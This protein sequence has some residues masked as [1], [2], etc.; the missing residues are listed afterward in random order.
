MLRNKIRRSCLLALLVAIT[1]VRSSSGQASPTLTSNAATL[2][3]ADDRAA[4][5]VLNRRI[6]IDL[7]DVTLLE[8]LF[9][10]RDLTGIN[11]VVGNEITG[12]V[13]AAFAD[14]QVHQVLDSLLIPRGYS[15]R[16]V[17][18]SLAILSL[19]SIG[20]MLP[21]FESRVIRL[22]SNS[23]ESLLSIVE[24][25][26]S[27]E[28]RVHAVSASNT[29]MIMDYADRIQLTIDQIQALE[30]AAADHEAAQ[31]ATN[32]VTSSP[33]AGQAGTY[34]RI[35]RPQFVPASTLLESLRPLLSSAGLVSALEE[36]DKIIVSDT[37][38]ALERVEQALVQLDV[39][40]PQVRIWALIYDCGIEDLEACGVNFSS[41][42]YG[43]AVDAASG[44]RNHS[45]LL[46]TITSPVAGPANGVMTLSTINRLG[47]V[48][49][50]VQA[51]ETSDDSRL[52]ADPNVVV[53]NHEQANIEIVTEV[54]YQQLTQGIDGGTIGTTEFRNAGVSLT[55]TP[56]IA[57]D[58]TIAMVINPRFSLLTGFT[59]GDNAPI[60]DRR[61]T[62]TT[63]RVQNLQTLVLGGLRQRTR[64]VEQSGIPGLKKIP[65]LGNL[66]KFDRRSARE[67]ELIVF[68]TP[69]IVT[70]MHGGSPR[71]ICLAETLKCEA[72]M[73][74]SSPVPFGIAALD[75]EK[76]AEKRNLHPFRQGVCTDPS[77]K[78]KESESTFVPSLIG[79][80]GR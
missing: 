7:R 43:S 38:E 4:R 16:V 5:A 15:Y 33:I 39:P 48:S 65:Y 77:C 22:Q 1:D 73:T 66:F 34:V 37:S 50:I 11:L 41:G 23:P 56:H 9:A 25:M 54:P 31:L 12:S 18:G 46:N 19:D 70:P 53:M 32:P 17:S 47:T 45:L 76:M 10:I 80:I 42:V 24:S 40:R 27:P 75:A 55:V 61:E 67:S 14:T 6:T 3:A 2:S 28:G 64:I 52:L 26:L 44:N 78:C 51:L 29:L 49:S 69:E 36:E 30:K 21:N 57:A 8:A 62:N 63:V 58:D 79:G 13:N 74:P 72:E 59:E 35:F 68:I 20:S 60:I 71:E